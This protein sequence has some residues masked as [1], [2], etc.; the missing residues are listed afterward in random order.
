[1][2]FAELFDRGGP[3]MW[4]I[5]AVSIIAALAFIDRLLALRRGLI[6]PS[7]LYESLLAHLEAG[8]AGRAR[9]LCRESATVL[10]RVAAAGLDRRHAGR[11]AAKEGMEEAGAVAIGRLD[12]W[13]GI[14]STVAAIAPLLGLLGTVTGMIEVFFQIQGTTNPDIARL[15]GGI[16]EALYTTGAGLTVGIPVF[17][18][19]RF[20]EAKIDRYAQELEERSLVLLDR[21]SHDGPDAA[22]A[23]SAR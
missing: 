8:D 18:A 20:I 1:M 19:Y 12:R 23:E 6:T 21:M 3:L 4:V 9:Q 5:L 2:N 16:K 7:S 13:V 14:L 22:P 10:A 11:A 17:V 15:S